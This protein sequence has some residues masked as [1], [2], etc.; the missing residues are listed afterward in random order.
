METVIF[1]LLKEIVDPAFPFRPP[2]SRKTLCPPCDFK[3]IC[4]TQWV[5]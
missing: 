1:S 5:S 3:Y 2:P 4:G